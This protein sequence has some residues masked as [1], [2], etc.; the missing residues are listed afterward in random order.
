LPTATAGNSQVTVSW[1]LPASSAAWTVQGYS[2]DEGT[3]SHHELSS[4]VDTTSGTNCTVT[5]L[6]DGTT[7]YFT[8]TAVVQ[9]TTSTQIVQGP[10]ST[11][12]SA[13][14]PG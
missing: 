11:E 8:V 12:A 14:P 4:P 6:T 7:Y 3:T 10:R 2:L 9:S 13:R 1:S 5:S